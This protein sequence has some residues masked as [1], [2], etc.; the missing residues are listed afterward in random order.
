MTDISMG[1][2]NV[3]STVRTGRSKFTAQ[4]YE[5]A[6]HAFGPLSFQMPCTTGMYLI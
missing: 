1:S 5:L 2:V 4:G 6:G 3:R